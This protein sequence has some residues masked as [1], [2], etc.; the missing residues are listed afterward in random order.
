M[1][2]TVPETGARVMPA[3]AGHRPGGAVVLASREEV[4]PLIPHLR[5]FARSLARGD[6]HL[7][8]DVV[9]DTLVLALRSW[10][11]FTPGTNLKAWLFTILRDRFH[12]LVGRRHL[13]AEVAGA[14]SSA[15]PRSRPS[16]RAGPSCRGSCAPSRR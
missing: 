10:G 5:A 8:D 15:W 13:T 1:T 4:V 3:Q 7:A 12:T 16:R 11:G 6:A 9:Q 14:T 2:L